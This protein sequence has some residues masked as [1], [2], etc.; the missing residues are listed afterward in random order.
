MG[1]F[2]QKL[3]NLIT[4]GNPQASP[5]VTRRRP[6]FTRR[7]L[8]RMESRIGG[9]LFGPVPKGHRREFFCLDRHTWVWY[10]EWTDAATRKKVSTTTRYEVHD[11]GIL[12]VQEGQPYKFVE[13]EELSNLVWAMHLYYEE[14]VR[15][16]YGYDPQTGKPLPVGARS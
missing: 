12:K 5:T 13:G 7:D 3:V 14:V 9:Q 16:I 2:A 15:N 6:R 4:G 8:I 11:N 10:E 1:V